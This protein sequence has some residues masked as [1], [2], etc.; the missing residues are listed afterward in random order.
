MLGRVVVGEHFGEVLRAAKA[1]DEAAFAT[2]YRDLA[3]V[4]TGYVRGKGAA[5][6]EDVAAEAFLAVA[7]NIRRFEGDEAAFRSWVFTIAHR[8]LVDERR[9]RGRGRSD[10]HDPATIPAETSS[11]SESVALA[12]LDTEQ[13]E[14]MLSVLTAD[15]R[16][17]VLL[18]IL[19]GLSVKETAG[20]LG[21][22]ESAVK[23]LQHRAVNALARHLGAPAVTD[24]AP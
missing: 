22:G 7:R 14:E 17:V 12:G 8:R 21:K 10:P 23:V 9:R 6:P 16:S 13:V 5:E 18:R 3:P 4:V 11:S 1:G 19:A 15:Q 24:S 20:V 2:I